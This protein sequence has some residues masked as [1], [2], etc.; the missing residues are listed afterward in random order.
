MAY[1][2][3]NG[4]ELRNKTVNTGISSVKPYTMTQVSIHVAV[5][6]QTSQHQTLKSHI[7]LEGLMT[8]LYDRV[9]R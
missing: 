3:D 8:D 4:T 7:Q 5:T 9:A 2:I 6:H 1:F